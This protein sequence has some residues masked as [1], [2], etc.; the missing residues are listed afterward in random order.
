MLLVGIQTGVN[1]ERVVLIKLEIVWEG[2][3]SL[4]ASEEI[5]LVVPFEGKQVTVEDG[6][7]GKVEIAGDEISD[8]T[9][10]KK[11]FAGSLA[12]FPALLAEASQVNELV[13]WRAEGVLTK[14]TSEVIPGLSWPSATETAATAA[15]KAVAGL[16]CNC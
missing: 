16:D 13:D 10:S 11:P 1:G 4:L 15:G 7:K 12:S 9:R 8:K 3:Q 6:T 2:W 5:F 14:I